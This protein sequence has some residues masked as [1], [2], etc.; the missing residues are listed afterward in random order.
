MADEILNTPVYD[1][2]AL[3]QEYLEKRKA[4]IE[5]DLQ[6]PFD[7]DVVLE[8]R[9]LRKCFP[10]SKTITGKVTRGLVAVDD[11]II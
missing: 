4:Q 11:M 8:V 7:P 3:E 5:E 1:D 6:K 2:A 9:H 10:M